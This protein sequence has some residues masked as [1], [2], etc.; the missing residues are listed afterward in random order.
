MQKKSVLVVDDEEDLR[1]AIAFDLKRKGYQVSEAGSGNEAFRMVQEHPFD[2]IVSDVRMP[3]GDGPNL[4]DRVVGLNLDRPPRLIFVSAFSDLMAKDAF[5]RGAVGVLPKPFERADLLGALSRAEKDPSWNC[6]ETA[7]E[8]ENMLV[9]G[10]G[11]LGRGGMTVQGAQPASGLA[12]GATI[13]FQVQTAEIGPISGR[14]IIR[15]NDDA[16][17]IEILDLDQAVCQKYAEWVKKNRPTAFIPIP[18]T[19]GNSSGES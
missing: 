12:T 7:L 17:G 16:L 14:G 1:F 15:W 5:D 2:I 9:T 10:D 6:L 3:D 8:I 19:S 13:R 18:K 11:I 4:L